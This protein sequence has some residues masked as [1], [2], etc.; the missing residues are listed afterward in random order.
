MHNGNDP[1][2]PARRAIGYSYEYGG[3]TQLSAALS[4]IPPGLLTVCVGIRRGRIHVMS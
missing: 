3:S 1:N 2:L 4:A